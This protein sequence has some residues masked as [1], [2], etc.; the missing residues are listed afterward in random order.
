MYSA[1]GKVGVFTD[2]DDDGRY[3]QAPNRRLFAGVDETGAYPLFWDARVED[4]TIDTDAGCRIG[5]EGARLSAA[6]AQAGYGP[7]TGLLMVVYKAQPTVLYEWRTS[8]A[9]AEPIA[10]QAYVLLSSSLHAQRDD[11]VVQDAIRTALDQVPADLAPDDPRVVYP[12][13]RIAPAS[14]FYEQC[15]YPTGG[16]HTSWSFTHAAHGTEGATIVTGY[17]LDNQAG[18]GQLGAEGPLVAFE[19]HGEPYSFP[20]GRHLWLD[21]D[22]LDGDPDRNA[23]TCSAPSHPGE[24]C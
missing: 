12:G 1:G 4:G 18:D 17:L 7:Q 15:G 22:P 6:M 13:D 24:A 5:N 21:V 8:Q 20:Q 10:G 19:P 11:R 2:K 14:D 9:F 3:D 16:Y 23:D